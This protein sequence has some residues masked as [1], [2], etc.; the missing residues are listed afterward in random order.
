MGALDAYQRKTAVLTPPGQG[1]VEPDDSA[2]AMREAQSQAEL[3]AAL[4]VETET[5]GDIELLEV[6]DKYSNSASK[7]LAWCR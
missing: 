4:L 5:E 7:M 2:A 6:V 3:Q 1:G